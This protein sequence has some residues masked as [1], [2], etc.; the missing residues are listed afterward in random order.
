MCAQVGGDVGV[1]VAEAVER[2]QRQM[3]QE[4]AADGEMA[5]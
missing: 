5:G 3:E 2:A 4:S 1:H